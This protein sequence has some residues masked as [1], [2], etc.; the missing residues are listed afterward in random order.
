MAVAGGFVATHSP[1]TSN[2][3]HASG[4]VL[5][6][7]LHTLVDIDQAVRTRPP[8]CA[9]TAVTGPAAEEATSPVGA[10][11]SKSQKTI[12]IQLPMIIQHNASFKYAH[13]C[14]FDWETTQVF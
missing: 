4:S 6:P 9:H 1:V 11:L 12:N 10:R 13:I 2:L 5:T 7:V 14:R 8:S 3:I